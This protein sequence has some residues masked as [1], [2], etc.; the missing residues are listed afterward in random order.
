MSKILL[1]NSKVLYTY[2]VTKNKN[3][4][5]AQNP[6]IIFVFQHFFTQFDK[7]RPD[8]GNKSRLQC[9]SHYPEKVGFNNLMVLMVT[10]FMWQTQEQFIGC[11]NS[12]L[13][14][15]NV[16]PFEKYPFYHFHCLADFNQ[17]KIV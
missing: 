8:I 6:D 13:G 10:F 7:A 12:S 3:T 16:A 5:S 4:S 1:I 15:G 14:I 2:L 9:I 11:V 17:L